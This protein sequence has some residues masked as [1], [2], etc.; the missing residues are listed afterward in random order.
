VVINGVEGVYRRSH[1]WEVAEQWAGTDQLIEPP[2]MEDAFEEDESSIS[3]PYQ[4]Q[5]SSA[6]SSLDHPPPTPMM[7]PGGGLTP[8]PPAIPRTS[9]PASRSRADHRHSLYPGLEALPLPA[10]IAP[11]EPP[12]R[13]VSRF[14]PNMSFDDILREVPK[15]DA[16]KGKKH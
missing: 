14:N 12:A 9:S 1:C 4:V 5:Q 15:K 13:P 2:M 7:M 3:S 8:P 16:H 11:I 6:G 10:G